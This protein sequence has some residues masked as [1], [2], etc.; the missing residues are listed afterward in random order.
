MGE[1]RRRKLLGLPP[2]HDKSKPINSIKN[3]CQLPAKFHSKRTVRMTQSELNRLLQ[4]M[5]VGE[6]LKGLT[7]IKKK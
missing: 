2:R 1:A 6:R 3:L 4:L 5:A 7:A